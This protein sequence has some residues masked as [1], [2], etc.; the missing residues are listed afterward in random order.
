METRIQGQRSLQQGERLQ[1]RIT[2]FPYAFGLFE[3][4]IGG[5]EDKQADRVRPFFFE[6]GKSNSGSLLSTEYTMT[7]EV[8]SGN[9]DPRPTVVPLAGDPQS[10][11][12]ADTGSS[13]IATDLSRLVNEI[14][15]E[16]HYSLGMVPAII[17]EDFSKEELATVWKLI[18]KVDSYAQIWGRDET[19]HKVR[20]GIIDSVDGIFTSVGPNRRPLGWG[21]TSQLL[22]PDGIFKELPKLA[23]G[24]IGGVLIPRDRLTQDKK[25]MLEDV[26]S[27][28]TGLTLEDLK[29]CAARSAADRSNTPIP[30]VVAI[31]TG[32]ERADFVFEVLQC[33][34]VRPGIINHLI[35]DDV[36]AQRLL[37]RIKDHLDT[38]KA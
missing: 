17:P 23:Y 32:P 15:I 29:S 38:R 1:V 21:K 25:V 6:P 34:A 22:R 13:V 35:V 18:G 10:A 9:D 11:D 19:G 31:C 36:F 4:G 16:P 26:I 8:V 3:N 20:P 28:W 12:P 27:R 7:T 24:D 37:A 14:L 33:A 5:T 2:G 30:G